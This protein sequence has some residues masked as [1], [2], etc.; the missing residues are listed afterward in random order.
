MLMSKITFAYS[1]NSVHS[2]TEIVMTHLFDTFDF[3]LFSNST[4]DA[5]IS[6]VWRQVL[7]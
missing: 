1:L 7:Y 5:K 3:V 4:E 2:M 6:E